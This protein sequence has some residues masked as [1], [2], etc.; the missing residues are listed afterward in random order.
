MLDSIRGLDETMSRLMQPRGDSTLLVGDGSCVETN[1]RE[2]CRRGF[3]QPILGQRTSERGMK[4]SEGRRFQG[5]QLFST[6][7]QCPVAC[8]C[9]IGAEFRRPMTE[10]T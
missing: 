9:E 2:I 7:G 8:W 10:Q 5:V 6:F 4:R 1:R 3:L